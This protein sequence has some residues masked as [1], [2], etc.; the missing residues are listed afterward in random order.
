MGSDTVYW[1]QVKIRAEFLKTQQKRTSKKKQ[2]KKNVEAEN[3][4]I[5]LRM[6]QRS[7]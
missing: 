5:T 4:I 1:V 3:N 2:E 7:L 6:K